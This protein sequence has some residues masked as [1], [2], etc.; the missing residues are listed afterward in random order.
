MGLLKQKYIFFEKIPFFILTILLSYSTYLTQ[1]IGKAITPTNLETLS[2]QIP[3]SLIS[4]SKYILKLLFPVDLALAYPK[5]TTFT[6]D[7]LIL[8]ITFLFCIS[9]IFFL[10]RKNRPHLLFGWCWYL[11]TLFPV[12]GIVQIGSH[13][14]AD[15]YAYIPF[16]GLYL[17]FAFEV[18][19]ILNKLK[20][21]KIFMISLYLFFITFFIYFTKLQVSYWKNNNTIWNNSLNKTKNNW[22]AHNN[23]GVSLDDNGATD[24]AISHFQRALKIKPDY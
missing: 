21:G 22:L 12:I 10:K 5:K 14:I 23:L 19:I 9:L 1:K 6:I 11:G 16:L 4:Y 7:E 8:S 17:M 13:T 2:H 18:Y 3:I 20:Y 15:R 24:E